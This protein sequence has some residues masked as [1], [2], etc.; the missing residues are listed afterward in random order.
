MSF[1]IKRD[2]TTTNGPAS[3]QLEIGEFAVNAI[4]GVLYFKL[5]DGS[6][7]KYTPAPV[8]TA[9]VPSISFGSV[10]EFCCN[11]DT[12]TATVTNLMENDSY[13]YELTNLNNNNVIFM[14]SETGDLLPLGSTTR[15]ASI[16]FSISGSQSI[17]LMKFSVKKN[18]VTIVENIVS[19]CC[20]N[21][22]SS[23]GSMF[24]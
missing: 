6:I 23:Q 17:T 7:V 20:Q 8:E 4:T 15:S 10:A 13:T 12:L 21:C 2:V 14:S 18:N 24:M 11:G 1:R 16:L 5:V 19:I 9:L 22:S 3:S